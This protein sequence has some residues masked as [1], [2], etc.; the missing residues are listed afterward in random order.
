MKNNQQNGLSIVIFVIS[1]SFAHAQAA[2]VET[3]DV[4][5][6]GICTAMISK[7]V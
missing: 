1:L 7:D 4:V 2:R 3:V 5:E 6:T